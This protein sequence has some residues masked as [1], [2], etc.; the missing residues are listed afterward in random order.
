MKPIKL[1]KYDLTDSFDVFEEL[2]E[3]FTKH[4]EAKNV[5]DESYIEASIMDILEQIK[6]TDIQFVKEPEPDYNAPSTSEIMERM[7]KIQRDLK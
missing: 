2:L 5:Q 3:L 7:Y 1:E 6:S 4:I